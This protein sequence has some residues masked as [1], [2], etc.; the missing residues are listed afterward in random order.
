VIC[1]LIYVINSDGI[2]AQLLHEI[3]IAL[4]LLSIDE[5]IVFDQLISDTC[6]ARVL[7]YQGSKYAEEQTLTFDEPLVAIARE[8]FGANDGYGW[9]SVQNREQ[10]S[11]EDPER[12]DHC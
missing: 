6:R 4:A 10:K 11:C 7:D 9:N 12:P 8:E 1:R 5:R 3:R 2:D